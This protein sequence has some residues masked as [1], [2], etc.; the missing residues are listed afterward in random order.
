M[1]ATGEDAWTELNAGSNT[2]T[3]VRV[4]QNVCS[5]HKPLIETLLADYSKYGTS[6]LSH[7]GKLVNKDIVWTPCGMRSTCRPSAPPSCSTGQSNFEFNAQL[8]FF[9]EYINCEK[10]VYFR[11]A[12][13]CKSDR[14]SLKSRLVTDH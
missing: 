5:Q 10:A 1:V 2:A 3:G 12:C 4:V 7:F 6:S 13:I 9:H 14:G 11:V 8:F